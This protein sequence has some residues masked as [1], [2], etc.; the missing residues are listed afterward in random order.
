M[1]VAVTGS[2]GLIGT[3]LVATLV[4]GGHRV[5]RVV[6]SRPRGEDR[7]GWD[8]AAGTVDTAGLAGVEAVVH[9]A[10]EGIASRRWT[11]DQKRRVHDSRTA[12]TALLARALAGL[13][14]RPAVL[15][16]ASAIGYYGDRGDEELTEASPP[17]EGF[18]AGVVVDWERAAHPAVEAGIRT[19]FLR[20][21]LVL[22]P[23]GGSLARMLPLFR[24][25]LGGRFGRGDQWW[26]WITLEDEVGAI[27][28]L[29]GA[30]VSGP[31]NLTA[32]NPVTNA[33]MTA[34]L[35]RVLRRPALVPIPPVG[36]ALVLGWEL[37]QTLLYSSARVLPRRLEASGYTFT[38]PTLEPALRAILGRTAG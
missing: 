26:P 3:A 11:G 31:V 12:G 8:P 30:E 27:V 35:A 18:L 28:H 23:R 21:G 36:P 37:A 7:V 14:P 15:C 16:S 33:E 2:S 9:L 38:H 20:T 13:D 34:T 19:A 32:P 10:G 4:A 1:E 17:G 6:R 25:G 22:T 24:L 5:R 29:L